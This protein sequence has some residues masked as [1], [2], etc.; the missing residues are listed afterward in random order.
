MERKFLES[1]RGEPE[2]QNLRNPL[3]VLVDES[4]LFVYTN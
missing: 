3:K 1:K 2:K 4:L